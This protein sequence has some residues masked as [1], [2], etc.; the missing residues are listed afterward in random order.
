MTTDDTQLVH[1]RDSTEEAFS[2]CRYHDDVARMRT[3]NPTKSWRSFSSMLISPA[4]ATI[5]VGD[6]DLPPKRPCLRHKVFV[7]LVIGGT[8]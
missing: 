7:F 2:A 8:G 6:M 1:F 5:A 3:L 4:D